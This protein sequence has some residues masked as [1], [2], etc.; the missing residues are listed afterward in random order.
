ILA[1]APA[2]RAGI[3]DHAVIVDSK[4]G[5]SGAGRGLAL[6]YHFSETD[7]DFVA[8]GL[9]GH[10]HLPEITQEP[11]LLAD[12]PPPRVTFVPHLAPIVRGIETT[13]YAD[14]RLD[15]LGLDPDTAVREI[16]R[17]FYADAP[18]TRVVDAA[19]HTKHTHGTTYC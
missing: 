19:P 13:C 9:K 11:G 17:E 5:I 10:R 7:E 18:F 4:S 2:Y 15:R 3:I 1:L 6:G 12:A 16:Y 8:Y 14:V